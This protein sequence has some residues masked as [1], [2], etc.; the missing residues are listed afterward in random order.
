MVV[1]FPFRRLFLAPGVS[2]IGGSAT[3]LHLNEPLRFDAERGL[4]QAATNMVAN[5]DEQPGLFKERLR[6]SPE[7]V[8]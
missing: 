2:Q 6:D 3:P 5:L 7:Q 4:K 8:K 1:G